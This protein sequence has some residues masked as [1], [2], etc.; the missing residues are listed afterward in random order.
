MSSLLTL[1][2]KTIKSYPASKSNVSTPVVS[3]NFFL[4]A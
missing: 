1:A 4:V 2:V 3:Y